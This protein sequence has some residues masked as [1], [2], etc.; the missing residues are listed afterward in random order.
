MAL[1]LV[2]ILRCAHGYYSGMDNE[3]EVFPCE[4][5][6]LTDCLKDRAGSFSGLATYENVGEGKQS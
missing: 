3:I 6:H 1:P 5:H 2:L 4:D